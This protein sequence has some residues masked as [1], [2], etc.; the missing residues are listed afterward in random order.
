MSEQTKP[1]RGGFIAGLLLGVLTTAVLAYALYYV[2]HTVQKDARVVG[3]PVPVQAVPAVVKV[4]HEAIGAS[5]V[6][7]PSMPVILT[8][9]VVSRVLRVPFDLGAV[10]K[11][12]DLL[13]ELDP[14]LYQ[15]NLNSARIDYDHAQ[16]Q[17]QRLEALMRKNYAAA[18]DLEKARADQAMAHDTVVRAEIDLANTR[19]A[20]PVPAVVLERAVNPGEITRLDQDLIELGVLNP[21]MMVAQVPEDK[22]GAVYLGM[23]GVV[24]T[25][26]FPGIDFSGT[27]AK[28]DSRVNDATR[29]FGVYIQLAN[30]DLRLKKGVTGYARL[31]ST[32]MA[33]A[34]PATAVMNPIGDR[35]SVY[36]VGNDKRAHLRAIRPGAV[37]DGMTEVL[38]G[39]DEHEQVVAAG[40]YDLR[41]NDPV[42]VNH[43]APWNN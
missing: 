6:I 24:A 29:T 14:R 7:Q 9:K 18:A 23:K 5:G 38:G 11:P 40:Q 39:L 35:A 16:R 12:G 42:S 15:A 1:S 31:E 30:R 37:V 3:L 32:K 36:V 41:D 26:A 33:L 25:D 10:V 4:L 43:F 21:V 17:V 28:I 13:V 2:S 34:I 19:V 20:S 8:A 22:I 27:V